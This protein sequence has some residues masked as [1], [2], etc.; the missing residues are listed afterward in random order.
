MIGA[1]AKACVVLAVE[2]SACNNFE[3]GMAGL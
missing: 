1:V 3:G 2:H